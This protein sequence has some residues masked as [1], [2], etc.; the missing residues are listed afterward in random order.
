MEEY[1]SLSLSERVNYLDNFTEIKEITAQDCKKDNLPPVLIGQRGIFARR[2]LKKNM[3]IGFYTGAYIADDDTKERYI[4]SIGHHNYYTYV[5]GFGSQSH[6]S[7]SGYGV[8]NRMTLVNSPTTYTGDLRKIARDLTTKLNLKVIYAKS[9][10]N[11]N[12]DILNNP[13]SY[14][15]VS[16][17]TISDI[18]RGSQL[19]IDYG[20]KYW[21]KKIEGYIEHTT[22]ELAK[23]MHDYQKQ[24]KT[25]HKSGYLRRSR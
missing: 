9:G 3:F 19:F 16:Y 4:Q 1:L 14:D 24:I 23:A 2:N 11:P 22:T 17:A 5:F 15:M 6:P 8:G 20:S 18:P 13:D 12:P 21:S 10:E 7:I 25:Q